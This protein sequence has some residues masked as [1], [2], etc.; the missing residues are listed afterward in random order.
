MLVL[1]HIFV[2]HTVKEFRELRIWAA[3]IITFHADD[4]G[5]SMSL[6]VLTDNQLLPFCFF[7]TGLWSWGKGVLVISFSP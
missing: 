5:V 1:F 3:K 6:Y 7:N 2:A 4:S